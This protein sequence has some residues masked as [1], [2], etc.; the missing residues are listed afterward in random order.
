M[1]LDRKAV[2]KEAV[3]HRATA[4]TPYFF[5]W[6]GDVGRGDIGVRLDAHYGG[7]AW[8]NRYRNYVQW[9]P[10]ADD[11]L[12]RAGP[13]YIRDVYGSGWRRDRRPV[14]LIDPVL[15]RPSLS[16]YTFP[17]PDALFPGDWEQRA[18]EEIERHAD[19]FTMAGIGQGLF[20][21]CWGLR[22]FLETLTD[23]AAEPEFFRDLVAAITEHQLQLIDRLLTVPFDAILL[24]D[25]WSD[26]RGVMIGPERWREV[27]KPA[28]A[29]LY[30]R[31]RSGGR[32]VIQHSCGSVAEIIPDLIEI[33]LD[34]LESVQPEAA[35]MDPYALKDRFGDR[36]TFWGGLGSQSVIP[37]GK[38]EELCREIRRLAA[39]MGRD[40]G[41][42]IA[43]SKSLQPE[44][45][46]ENAAAMLEEFLMLGEESAYT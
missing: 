46:V 9:C 25:D 36:L 1:T 17:D 37:H 22:G 15:K 16:G 38:P 40:G 32:C 13:D 34:V 5:T 24:S 7:R 28:V 39:H 26:Q 14:H 20:E 6:E 44:T 35:G 45:P 3:A 43:P 8:R 21:R 31:I 27:I 19:C 41:F 10:G 4:V 12:Y 2:V 18:C 29:G 11:G 42:I 23:C 30:R 33:G